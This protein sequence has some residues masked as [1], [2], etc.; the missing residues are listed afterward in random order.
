MEP[1]NPKVSVIIPAY[2]QALYLGAAIESVFAQTYPNLEI[3]VVDDG[4]TDGTA[5]VARKYGEKIRYHYQSNHGLAGARNSGI[6]LAQGEL[7]GLLDADDAWQ[8]EFLETMVTLSQENPQAAVFY[9]QA[10]CID[11]V[12][13]NLG[14]IVGGQGDEIA[15]LR[16]VILRANF[17]IPS[18]IVIRRSVFSSAGLFDEQFQ[19]VGCE[20]LD[21]WLRLTPEH[22][23]ISSPAVLVRYRVHEKSLSA[24]PEKMQRAMQEVIEKHFGPD[25]ACFDQWTGEKRR[26]YGSLYRNMVLTS[27][28]RQNDW[29]SGDKLKQ[30]I[31][32][33]PSLVEDVDLFYELGLGDQ[34]FGR[35]GTVI[36][37]DLMGNE[38]KILNL[39]ERI[40]G[41]SQSQRSRQ[42]YATAFKSL[43]LIAYNTGQMSLFR[44]YFWL[45]GKYRPEFWREKLMISNFLKS[46]LGKRGLESLRGLLRRKRL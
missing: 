33:D 12:G 42:A 24:S 35:R 6:R 18:T 3:I 27:I 20:D 30:A 26:A 41:A 38:K 36:S 17:L 7:I 9:C 5:E 40:F 1:T 46:F 15:D 10:I 13:R 44:R 19:W 39:L 22:K 16:S 29:Q 11:E 32:A 21:L 25:D 14:Q 31:Q 43:G 2:N 23:F 28:Q 37:L 45:A 8:P 34:P 4:S